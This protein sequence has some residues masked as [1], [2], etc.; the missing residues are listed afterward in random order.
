MKQPSVTI[1]ARALFWLIAAFALLI[2]PQW[3]R[4][5]TWLLASCIVLAG[6]RWLAQTGRVRLP[7]RWMR[8]LIML[9][10]T[11]AYIASVGGHFTV[12][13]ASSFF[14]LAVGLK[15]LETRQSRDFYVLFFILVYLAAVNFLFQQAI[16]WTLLNLVGV[17][18]LLVGLQVLNAPTLSGHSLA[19]WRRL[20]MM[21]IKTLPV[22]LL[23]FVFFPRLAPLWSV[24]MVSGQ[25]RTGISDS[26]TPGQI[27]DLAQSSE[28]AF[29]VSF[30]GP[31]PPNRELYWRGL[32]LDQFDGETWS[33]RLV[34]PLRGPSPVA[35]D[36]GAGDLGPNDYGI[37]LEPTNARWAFSLKPSVALSS[38]VS[39]TDQS[40]F[41]FQRPADT[42]VRYRLRLISGDPQPAQA[43]SAAERRRYLQL[44]ANSN[45]R[46]TD[47]AQQL[48]GQTGEPEAFIGAVMQ[49]FR[50]QPYFYTLRPPR[51][52]S[53][54]VDALLFDIKRG[55]CAHYASAMAFLLRSAGIPA[56][57]VVGYQ[58][59]SRG[60]DDQYLIVRQY[61]AHAWVEAWI[62]RQG[63]V[64]VD[65]TAAI[66]PQRIESGLREAVADEGSFLEN[67][68]TSPER[69][70]NVAAVQWVTLQLDRINYQWQR[71]VVGYQGQSQLDLMARLP[72]HLSFRDLGYVTAGLVAAVLLVAGV[73]SAWRQRGQGY[74]DPWQRLFERGVHL[75][76]QAGIEVHPGDT[77]ATIAERAAY[78]YPQAQKPL[79][80]FAR[81]ANN[82]YYGPQADQSAKAESR[83]NLRR[84]KARLSQ[85]RRALRQ[86]RSSRKPRLNR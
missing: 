17:L 1:P 68:W 59:G 53:D 34:A 6:W 63:W 26:M 3:Q 54:S 33:Q 8:A 49:R 83:Q 9:A 79:A 82:H 78:R 42:A 64:R 21:L 23:L 31:I 37:L 28:R 20:G 41:Q 7:G 66:S 50:Q 60:L 4:L 80:D 71:W 16:G 76:R 61:D 2:A 38:N 51:M 5:P 24:P 45:P 12:D 13:T 81:L 11:A 69:Y 44:P 29:R 56:R 18:L 85:L 35:L 47:Y 62:D 32:I 58:G 77:P 52:P 73:I 10:L 36:A 84:L 30:G 48:A 72:G 57:I 22:V 14:V 43:L 15:W 75:I 55:F 27:S 67:D 65:P 39:S 25:G 46:A 40:L 74:R 70:G 19:G 86:A